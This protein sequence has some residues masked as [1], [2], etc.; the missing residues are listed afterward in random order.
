MEKIIL[1]GDV[2][3]EITLANIMGADKLHEGKDIN[4]IVTTYGGSVI[5][6]LKIYEYL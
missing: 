5:E 2:G 4:F 6:A 3:F 1:N